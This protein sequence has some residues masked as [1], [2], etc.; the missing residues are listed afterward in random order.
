MKLIIKYVFLVIGSKQKNLHV[1]P[2]G[3]QT[4]KGGPRGMIDMMK[5][6]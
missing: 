4:R 6:L 3:G 1:A 2:F 5:K